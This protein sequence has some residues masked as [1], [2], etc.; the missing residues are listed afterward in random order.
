MIMAN[1]SILV[2]GGEVGSNGAPEPSLEIMPKPD[3]TGDTWK[4]LDYLNRTDPNNLYPFLHVLPSGR[5]FIGEHSCFTQFSPMLR[6]FD[7]GFCHT[8]FLGYYNEARILDPVSLDTF[9]VLPNMPG[10]VTS[11]LAGRTYPM[12][13]TA[14]LLPQH[15]P[16]T[17]PLTVL[18]CGGSNFGVALDNCVSIQPEVENPTWTLERMVSASIH[19]RCT[20][21]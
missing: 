7:V 12:E 3:G 1:G 16:Y 8:A 20:E 15:A 5:I 4:F 11:P 9:K 17:D 6:V 19:N 14:V 10:S 18:V 21:Y 13:G 2:V